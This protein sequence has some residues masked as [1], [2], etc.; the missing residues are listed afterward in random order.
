LE[1]GA[2]EIPEDHITRSIGGRLSRSIRTIP[3]AD[4]DLEIETEVTHLLKHGGPVASPSLK[5]WIFPAL[6]CACSYALYNIFIKKGKVPSRGS[7]NLYC[8]RPIY[9]H[10]QSSCFK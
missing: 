4:L 9:S 3:L 5:V 2:I 8:R 10:Y 6:T 1:A 7:Q